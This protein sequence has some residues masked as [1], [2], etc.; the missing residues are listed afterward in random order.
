[1]KVEHITTITVATLDDLARACEAV[2]KAGAPDAAEVR[3][4][5]PDGRRPNVKPQITFAWSTGD[6]SPA[7]ARGQRP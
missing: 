1:M 3:V 6:E 2:R 7:P 4:S 5:R